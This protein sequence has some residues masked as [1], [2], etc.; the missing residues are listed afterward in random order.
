MSKVKVI[1]AKTLIAK[2]K[3]HG[4]Y[5]IKHTDAVGY[6]IDGKFGYLVAGYYDTRIEA[7]VKALAKIEQAKKNNQSPCWLF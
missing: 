4:P 1:T 5:T 6:F 7:V 2:L 3:K